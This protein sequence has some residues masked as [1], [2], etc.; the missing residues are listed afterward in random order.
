MIDIMALRQIYE[1]RELVEVRWI[2][3]AT[4]PAD[5]MTKAAPNSSLQKLIDINEM[6]IM[7]EGW[8]ERKAITA[9][10]EP[11]LES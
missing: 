3:G 7:V 10:I 9:V 6:E 8:I 1:R 5:V 11:H 4:N 2:T